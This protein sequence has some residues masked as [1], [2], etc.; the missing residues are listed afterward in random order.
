MRPKSRKIPDLHLVL[1]CTRKLIKICSELAF[2][3]TSK[4]CLYM[5]PISLSRVNQTGFAWLHKSN[6]FDFTLDTFWDHKSIGN[7]LRG[8]ERRP[9]ERWEGLR[10]LFSSISN[11][12]NKCGKIRKSRSA[13]RNQKTRLLNPGAYRYNP[14]GKKN[15]TVLSVALEDMV[16]R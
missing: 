3:D 12:A 5:E 10:H 16:L 8:D 15:A 13:E 1:K 2:W 4:S 6:D 14:A 9:R 11:V 7:K